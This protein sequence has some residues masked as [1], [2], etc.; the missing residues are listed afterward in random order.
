MAVAV[1]WLSPVSITGVMP[2][3]FSDATAS[4]D[5]GLMVSATANSATGPV[6]EAS[7]L[8]VRPAS[9]CV[10]SSASS[11]GEH[12]PRSSISRWLPST[13]SLPPISA[14]TPRPAMALKSLASTLLDLSPAAIARDT[15][16]S[17]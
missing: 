13:Q 11:A 7:R 6:S 16:W 10:R 2:S 3:A 9:S 5:E 12:W 4:R 1:A 14:C 15:G 8:T 17:E